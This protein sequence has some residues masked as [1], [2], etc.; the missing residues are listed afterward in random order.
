MNL[1]LTAEVPDDVPRLVRLDAP[2]HCAVCPSNERQAARRTLE[3]LARW[4]LDPR[5][6]RE[7][8]VKPVIAGMQ[9][10]DREATEA[11]FKIIH[12][13]HDK[14]IPVLLVLCQHQA[15][16]RRPHYQLQAPN[17]D[18]GKGVGNARL[19]DGIEGLKEAC[20][21]TLHT[22]RHGK[23]KSI[24]LH[25]PLPPAALTAIRKSVTK[26]VTDLRD[27]YLPGGA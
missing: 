3:E 2:P 10:S 16:K 14:P 26:L 4:W 8:S 11:I 23:L 27:L 18:L 24:S 17:P 12:P 19:R 7:W 6:G 22:Y 13:D 21:G 1:V 25:E 5:R 9:G 15:F 20:A